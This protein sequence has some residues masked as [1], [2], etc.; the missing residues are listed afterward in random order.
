MIKIAGLYFKDKL[1]QESIA[2]RFSI[3]KYKVIRVLR[4]AENEGI[5]QI[6]ILNP[7]SS[8]INI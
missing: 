8:N 4:R 7:G 5:V 1:T 6:N 2:K 3:S